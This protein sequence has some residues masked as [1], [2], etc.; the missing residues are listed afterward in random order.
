[1]KSEILRLLYLRRG[2]FVSGR[3]IAEAL[4][5]SRVAVKKHIDGLIKSGYCIEPRKKNGYMLGDTGDIFDE[6]SLKMFLSLKG[7]DIDVDFYRQTE[8]TNDIAKNKQ[9]FA[10]GIV[11]AAKQTQGRGRR[12]REFVSDEGGVY[13]SYYVRPENLTPFDAVKAV[14]CAAAAAHKTLSAYC[15][16]VV[17]WP[18]DI[19]GDGKKIC[20]LLCE[21]LS[22][23]ERVSLIIQAAGINVNNEIAPS[24]KDIAASLKDITGKN[25]NRAELCAGFVDNLRYFNSLLFGGNFGEALDYYKKNCVTL[26]KEVTVYGGQTFSGVAEDIDEN[27]FLTVKTESGATEKVI[28][29]DVSVR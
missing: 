16:C 8:S 18:N 27:G 10:E 7:I 3:E 4:K 2:E 12:G 19:L 21:M 26:N 15:G 11:A 29:G 13:L 17:K 23:S 9:N 14:I 22:E 24:I 1:M 5:I 20:G 28:Y 25:I 6:V